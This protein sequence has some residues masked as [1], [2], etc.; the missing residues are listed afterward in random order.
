MHAEHHE[1]VSTQPP[2]DIEPGWKEVVLDVLD[3]ALDQGSPLH[4]ARVEANLRRSLH[5]DVAWVNREVAAALAGIRTA[6]DDARVQLQVTRDRLS[7]MAKYD[8]AVLLDASQVALAYFGDDFLVE[9]RNVLYARTLYPT[10]LHAA[11]ARL[12]QAKDGTQPRTARVFAIVTYNFDDLLEQAIRERNQGF[13]V[14]CS[15][16]GRLVANRGGTG[17]LPSAIDIYHVHGIA[18]AGWLVDLNGVDLVFTQSQYAAQYGDSS[19]VARSVQ[20]A[21]FSSAPG[22][23]LGSSLTDDHAVAELQ[24]SYESN[25][26]WFHY[27]VLRLPEAARST[28]E[29]LSGDHFEQLASRFTGM[30]LR[31]LWFSEFDE[32]ASIVDRVRMNEE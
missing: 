1:L 9:L 3:H 30:G 23:I 2:D 7:A 26:G 20:S 5:G 14:H 4:R 22:L 18:P 28:R 13:T 31:V 19:T 21:F 32:I 16:R 12:V 11:I 24:R 6:T 27:A 17:N 29:M 8:D 15:Q 10:P 25:P